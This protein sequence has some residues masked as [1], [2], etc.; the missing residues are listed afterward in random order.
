MRVAG[1]AAC[2]RQRARTI[3]RLGMLLYAPATI[4]IS[5][6]RARWRARARA[7]RRRIHSDAQLHDHERAQLLRTV[8]MG[9][10]AALS[11]MR[12]TRTPTATAGGAF[13]RGGGSGWSHS[14]GGSGGALHRA[15]AG[16]VVAVRAP[17]DSHD[18]ACAAALRP[19][20][21]AARLPRRDEALPHSA[22][23]AIRAVLSAEQKLEWALLGF[24]PRKE[25]P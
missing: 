14:W 4:A 17:C 18:A 6:S 13:A 22:A 15:A 20:L 23:G 10:R 8:E 21:V 11:R 1:H 5:T 3:L 2:L 9:C 24:W 16:C 7:A 25:N 19:P 12:T